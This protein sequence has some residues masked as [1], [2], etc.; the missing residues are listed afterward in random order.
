LGLIPYIDPKRFL[1]EPYSKKSDVYSVGVLLWEISSGK[2]PFEDES[3]VGLVMQILQGLREE[4]IPDTPEDYSNL[5][6]GKY[7][8]LNSIIIY[9]FLLIYWNL[10][11]ECWSNELD[12]RP[13]MEQVVERLQLKIKQ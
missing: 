12:E 11:L 6:T 9:E 1:N 2:P 7:N 5:Y 10:I 8:F 13:T 3:H 4:I